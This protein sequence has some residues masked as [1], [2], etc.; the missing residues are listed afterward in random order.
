MINIIECLHCYYNPYISRTD[1]AS[2]IMLY[3]NNLYQRKY[4]NTCVSHNNIEILIMGFIRL[5]ALWLFYRRVYGD[6][7]RVFQGEG[8]ILFILSWLL[9]LGTKQ[10][11]N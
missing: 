11:N 6:N 10:N 2:D 4:V 1:L 8:W 7:G 9:I 5:I 3:I